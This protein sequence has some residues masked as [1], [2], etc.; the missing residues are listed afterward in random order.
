LETDGGLLFLTNIKEN[1]HAE[2]HVAFW[3]CKLSGKESILK[4]CLRWAFFQYN[5]N[6]IEAF[7]PEYS[8]SLHRFMEKKLGFVYEG[9]M[10]KRMLYKGQ[11]TDV[12]IYSILRE[13]V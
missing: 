9:R 10:R 7:I 4:D 12:K 6:R 5:L 13:E 1:L 8:R 2:V 11:F 3:D